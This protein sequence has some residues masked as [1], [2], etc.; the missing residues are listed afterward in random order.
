[1]RKG[2]HR[3]VL[4]VHLLPLRVLTALPSGVLGIGI[5]VFLL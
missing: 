3:A 1:M 4:T 2:L 5:V